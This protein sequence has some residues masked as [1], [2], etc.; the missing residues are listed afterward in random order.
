[1]CAKDRTKAFKCLKYE[2]VK[3]CLAVQ[4]TVKAYNRGSVIGTYI[5]KYDPDAPR[6]RSISTGKKSGIVSLAGNKQY[7]S[8]GC[9]FTVK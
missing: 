5:S 8:S 4:L 2:R 6:T 9:G 1:M 3:P 7:Y